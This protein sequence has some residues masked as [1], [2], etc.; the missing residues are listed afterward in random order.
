M[1]ER[2]STALSS[3]KAGGLFVNVAFLFGVLVAGVYVI[4]VEVLPA[5][6]FTLGECECEELVDRG[7]PWGLVFVVGLLV[8]PKMLGA[9]RASNLLGRL[10][11]GRRP[12]DA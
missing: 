12:P 7:V 9:D 5:L 11:P 8:A 2:I 3:P 4:G 6:G 1:P 10:L